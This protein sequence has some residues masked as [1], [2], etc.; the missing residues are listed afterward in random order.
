MDFH[1]LVSAKSFHDITDLNSGI[2]I[3]FCEAKIGLSITTVYSLMPVEGSLENSFGLILS[4][5]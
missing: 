4:L 1:V 3:G 5:V 2:T